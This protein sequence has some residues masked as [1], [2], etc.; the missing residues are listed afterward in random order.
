[1][2]FS[3]KVD[4]VPVNKCLNFGGYPVQDPYRDI[5]KTCL[6]GGVHCSNECWFSMLL[7]AFA[8][9]LL[10]ACRQHT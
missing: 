7:V 1:M 5:G 9:E 2:N 10:E 4:N 6:G 8:A 3:R